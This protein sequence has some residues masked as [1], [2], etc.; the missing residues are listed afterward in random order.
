M[1]SEPV[2]TV[3]NANLV[4]EAY[5]YWPTFH[6]ALLT[7][8]QMVEGDVRLLLYVYDEPVDDLP[9]QPWSKHDLYTTISIQCIGVTHLS[10]AFEENSI[11]EI[12]FRRTETG[13]MELMFK[14]FEWKLDRPSVI[15][16][17]RVC[18]EWLKWVDEGE[19][20][21]ERSHVFT[22]SIQPK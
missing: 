18:V 6:D 8:V 11:D 21:S 16:C 4:V 1:K 14:F 2:E 15:R 13:S 20:T 19:Y 22:L 5:G 9:H 7:D 10:L 17:D 12:S 3:E